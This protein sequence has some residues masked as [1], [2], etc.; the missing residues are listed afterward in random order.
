MLQVFIDW[1]WHSFLSQETPQD[2]KDEIA[3]I[4]SGCEAIRVSDCDAYVTRVIALANAP[5]DADDFLD[6]LEDEFMRWLHDHELI[7]LLEGN[8]YAD[9]LR[10]YREAARK[11]KG[12]S[13]FGLWGSRTVSGDVYSGRNLDWTKDSGISKFKLMTV[14]VPDGASPHATLGF[15]GFWGALAGM[16]K[17]GL[18]VHEANL[19]ESVDT[20]VGFPWSLRL[21][22]IMEHATSLH[23]GVVMWAQSNNTCGFNHQLCS[24]NDKMCVLMETMAGYTAY[25]TDNDEREA[26]AMYNNTQGQIVHLGRPLPHATMRTNH[27]YDPTIRKTYNWKTTT[28]AFQDSVNRYFM[29]SEQVS[30]YEANNIP[31]GYM[32]AIN[33]TS[34]LGHKGGD[35]YVCN[36]SNYPQGSN[37]LSVAFWPTKGM[38]YSAWEDGSAT[39][40]SPAA[41]NTYVVFDMSKF[42]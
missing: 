8:T 16:S 33:T 24:A 19:E 35:Y 9:V 34:L 22:W 12:C 40:W 7:V 18:T 17:S 42:W 1:Q 37:I 13:M 11:L 6:V 10:I 26:N 14:Y 4:R 21:R 28:H 15:V 36:P 2:F 27:G 32:Q 25:F 3:G 38:L 5:G 20:F 30:M 39:S 41:C 29:L 23:D 31:V